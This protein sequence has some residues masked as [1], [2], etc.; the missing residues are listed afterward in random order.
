[1]S[2]ESKPRSTEVEKV[3]VGEGFRKY[4]MDSKATVHFM[5]KHREILDD[6][7][8]SYYESV[9]KPGGLTMNSA[10]DRV[11]RLQKKKL[12]KAR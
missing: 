10:I 11:R 12:E 2:T 7:L 6:D 4:G 9:G 5:I 1:M 8:K 3:L